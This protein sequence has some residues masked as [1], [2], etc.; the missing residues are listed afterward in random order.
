MKSRKK[1]RHTVS[2]SSTLCTCKSTQAHDFTRVHSPLLS[3]VSRGGPPFRLPKTTSWRPSYGNSP[4]VADAETYSAYVNP[5]CLYSRTT[6]TNPLPSHEISRNPR[7]PRSN[8][9]KIK[10]CGVNRLEITNS[11]CTTLVQFSIEPRNVRSGK[12]FH[13]VRKKTGKFV[14]KVRDLLRERNATVFIPKDERWT[15]RIFS[16]ILRSLLERNKTLFVQLLRGSPPL[17]G[18]Q[19]FFFFFNCVGRNHVGILSRLA[20]FAR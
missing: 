17:L 3:S 12:M 15:V 16:A 10:R 19:L 13:R 1:K 18:A 14:G 4:A 6:T 2:L 9:R 20:C 7:F 5:L 8:Q 11:S